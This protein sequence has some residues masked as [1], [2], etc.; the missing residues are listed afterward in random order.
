[1]QIIKTEKLSFDFNEQ[2]I[3]NRTVSMMEDI[4]QQSEDVDLVNYANDIYDAIVE[5]LDRYEE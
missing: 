1:M 3:L 4:M 5:M 2:E